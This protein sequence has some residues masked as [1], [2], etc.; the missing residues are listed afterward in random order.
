MPGCRGAYSVFSPDGRCLV[1][2]TDFEYRFWKTGGWEA[3][4]RIPLGRGG[5]A[6]PPGFSPDGKLLAVAK[7]RYLLQ[8]ID[9]ASGET[10]ATLEPPQPIDL[11]WIA[12]SPDGARLAA[13]SCSHVC[14]HLGPPRHPQPAGPVA[15]PIGNRPRELWPP[16]RKSLSRRSKS[17][18]TKVTGKTVA[19]FCCQASRGSGGESSAVLPFCPP[20]PWGWGRSPSRS[21]AGWRPLRS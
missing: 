1:T 8:L 17:S 2:S 13:L 12:F 6:C 14:A 3:D 5:R 4:Q 7:S 21:V 10:V 16:T 18:S 19:A 20:L 9:V 15:S 11:C